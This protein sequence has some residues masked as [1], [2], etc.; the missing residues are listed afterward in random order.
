M[1]LSKRKDPTVSLLVRGVGAGRQL[2]ERAKRAGRSSNLRGWL[3]SGGY[4]LENKTCSASA[5]LDV[6]GPIL[7]IRRV[8]AKAAQPG[9]PPS[10]LSHYSSHSL[11]KA[12]LNHFQLPVSPAESNPR[13]IRLVT[14]LNSYKRLAATIPSAEL[15]AKRKRLRQGDVATVG[16]LWRQRMREWGI[17][18]EEGPWLTVLRPLALDNFLALEITWWEKGNGVILEAGICACRCRNIDAMVS[19]RFH[20]GPDLWLARG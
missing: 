8:V 3:K 19:T 11:T 2:R 16:K 10:R 4:A 15:N 5:D 18:R 14:D 12:F 7:Q 1:S 17:H 6:D 20:L 9:K 13:P